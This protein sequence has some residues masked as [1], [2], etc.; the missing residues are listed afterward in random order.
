MQ[1]PPKN[2]YQWPPEGLGRVPYWVY[3]DPE[4]YA[5]EQTRIFSGPYWN[6]VALEAEI[7]KPGDFTFPGPFFFLHDV[8]IPASGPSSIRS[9]VTKRAAPE[10][11]ETFATSGGNESPP[12]R[13]QPNSNR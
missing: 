7:P 3:S 5:L 12:H 8:E 13:R 9:R 2:S 1:N 10:T 6:Y 11:D 4:V